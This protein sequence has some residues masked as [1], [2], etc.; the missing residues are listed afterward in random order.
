MAGK[1]EPFLLCSVD[2]WDTLLRRRCHPDAVKLHVANQLRLR[3]PEIRHDARALLAL[4][5]EVERE[6]AAAS[7]AAGFDDEYRL[8]EVLEAWISRAAPERDA[9]LLALELGEEEWQ[10]E[11]RVAYADPGIA[12][13]LDRVQ[14][15]RWIFLS[16]F[17]MPAQRL[18]ALLEDK[19]LAARFDA[20]HS[21][22]DARLNKRSGRLYAEV[23]QRYH[24]PAGQ[25]CHVGDNALS[26]VRVPR[27]LGMRA[28]PYNPRAEENLRKQAAGWLHN[29]E[30]LWRHI[31][32]SRR[33][34]IALTGAQAQAWRCGL[35]LAPLFA[36]LALF[37]AESARR[38]RV[39]RLFFCTR[40]GEFLA[41]CYEVLRQADPR[42]A[43][44]TPP[45]ELLEVSRQSTFAASIATPDAAAMMRL[46][47]VYPEQSM[48]AWALSLGLEAPVVAGW[49]ERHGLPFEQAIHQPWEDPR[50]LQLLADPLVETALR[51][52]CAG[53]RAALLGYLRAAA[54]PPA[55]RIGLV[56]IGWR[57]SIQDNLA[58]VTPNLRWCGYYLGLQ[59]Y[60]GRPAPDAKK[61]AF[62]P[63][64]N[65]ED[66]WAG[67]FRNLPLTE[68]LCGSPGGSVSGYAP[69]AGGVMRALRL[70][71]AQEDAAHRAV[72]RHVQDGI[73]EALAV[74]AGHIHDQAVHSE[75]LRPLAL[76]RWSSLVRSPPPVLAEAFR[77]FK[78]NELFGRGRFA[79][80][81]LS[82]AAW[83][84][85]WF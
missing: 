18:Q 1:A 11:R 19:G 57:G 81:P 48:Q 83:W 44:A 2:V 28:V 85:R 5:L 41:R 10:Q 45:A 66:A 32:G 39:E 21:S 68:M 30:A 84:R 46:W 79:P 4:R 14:A 31:E 55:G 15:R 13:A 73:L 29:R 25:S 51:E 20:G 47:S 22:C 9:R 36:G 12:A 78:H 50:V 62:G 74:W 3:C 58:L 49:C 16:D 38:D 67:C 60:L 8:A 65:R 42:L 64:L 6:Q 61:L 40:E 82:R 69:D 52:L 70:A 7:R 33:V 71:D 35:H 75:E 76:K 56:D 37:I 24:A 59:K 23:Q 80:L 27:R 54:V 17:Y 43:L 77:G 34:R 53:K 63:D 72:V 26:D